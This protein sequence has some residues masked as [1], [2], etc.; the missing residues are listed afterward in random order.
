MSDIE[1]L[2]EIIRKFAE[3]RAW[4]KFHTPKNLALAI[5]GEVGELAA[6]F[7][8]L[9][10]DEI[11]N[12]NETALKKIELEIAD[13]GIYLLRLID[14]LNL[15]LSDLILEKIKINEDRFPKIK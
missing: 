8:W 5:S 6:E 14:V 4:V 3:E 13:V 15:N 11:Q 12:L 7:Q 10:D 9:S 2:T 1:N